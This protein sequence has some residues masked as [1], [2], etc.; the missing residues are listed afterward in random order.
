MA[1][2]N[3][4]VAMVL[5][6]FEYLIT[7]G[8]IGP[9]VATDIKRRLE[10][11]HQREVAELK[12]QRKEALAIASD[13]DKCASIERHTDAMLKK[14]GVIVGLRKEVEELRECLEQAYGDK[15]GTYTMKGNE[16]ERWRKALREKGGSK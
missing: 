8:N 14:N 4:T 12:R 13:I 15:I 5:L 6:N 11:A 16:V 10:D 3:E 1:S 2:E 9:T 7:L